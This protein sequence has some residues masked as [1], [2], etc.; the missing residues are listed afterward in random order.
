[1]KGSSGWHT[2]TNVE[3]ISRV[4]NISSSL[5][6]WADL[7]ILWY[8]SQWRVVSLLGAN[9]TIANNFDRAKYGLAIVNELLTVFGKDLG[10]GY[11]I[12]CSFKATI[13]KSSIAAAAAELQ[14]RLCVPSFHGFAHNQWCQLHNHPL[15]IRCFGLEDLEICERVFTASNGCAKLTRHSTQFHCLQFLDM[16]F[17]QWDDDKYAELSMFLF[18]GFP[19]RD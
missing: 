14:L 18:T 12:A 1:M 3:Y 6:P 10:L 16:H 17:A 4:R 7:D 2:Q 11:D 9:L 8:D 19:H 13:R 15:Y 5:S